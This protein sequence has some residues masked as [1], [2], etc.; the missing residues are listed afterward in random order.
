MRRR[1]LPCRIL[2]GV[3][4]CVSDARAAV[5]TPAGALPLAANQRAER[6]V[7]LAASR[8]A[9]QVLS[10]AGNAHIGVH[11]G[12]LELH[13]LVDQVEAGIAAGLVAARAQDAFEVVHRASPGPAADSSSR[14]LRRASCSVL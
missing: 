12:Q 11:A 10:H 8:A 4:C 13:V 9:D 6:L 14:S 5:L 1:V 2:L 3:G 7:L